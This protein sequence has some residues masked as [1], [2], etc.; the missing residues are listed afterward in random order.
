MA[1]AA[2]VAAALV[3]ANECE[4]C[5]AF[6]GDTFGGG[7]TEADVECAVKCTSARSRNDDEATDEIDVLRGSRGGCAWWRCGAAD[8][9]RLNCGAYE[10]NGGGAL[11]MLTTEFVGDSEGCGACVLLS[12]EEAALSV[13]ASDSTLALFGAALRM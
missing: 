5:D 13:S 8:A 4:K 10:K 9:G 2:A 6:G 7:K 11:A 1:A 3:T 12:D